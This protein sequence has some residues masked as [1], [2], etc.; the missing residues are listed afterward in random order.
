MGWWAKLDHAQRMERHVQEGAAAA[1]DAPWK[2][3]VGITV[4]G[5]D[6]SISGTAHDALEKAKILSSL[7]RVEGH[8]VVHDNLDLLPVAD[9]YALEATKDEAGLILNGVV[10]DGTQKMRI[11]EAY[12]E[13]NIDGVTLASGE[14]NDDWA[15][16]ALVSLQALDQLD[17]GTMRM[18]ETVVFISGQAANMG[19]KARVEGQLVMLPGDYR[20]NSQITAPKEI[21]RI[22]PSD[23]TG[24]ALIQGGSG[25]TAK[26]V[27]NSTETNQSNS[28]VVEGRL[29]TV[30]A[31]GPWNDTLKT[32]NLDASDGGETRSIEP[33]LEDDVVNVPRTLEN[34]QEVATLTEPA[35][36][37]P[38]QQTAPA[39]TLTS[40]QSQTDAILSEAQIGFIPSSADLEPEARAVVLK[41]A[42]VMATCVEKANLIAI[43]SGHTDSQGSED[44]NLELSDERAQAVVA[45]LTATGLPQNRLLSRGFGESKPIADN[46]TAEGRAANRRTEIRWVTN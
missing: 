32:A 36:V 16:A 7:D 33:P 24:P 31:L 25:L 40:C 44:A 6:I 8:R 28:G 12:P 43:V 21:V 29:P 9:I 19:T 11:Q 45:Q 15:P 3:G 34:A 13:A 35:E 46:A 27:T 41:L 23:P 5:R 2:H 20:H 26:T 37:A 39:P 30:V 22:V 10:A 18:E 14:P 38:V 17:H 1:I 42:D 4:S